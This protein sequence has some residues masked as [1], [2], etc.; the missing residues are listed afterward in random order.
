MRLIFRLRR[1]KKLS[2]Q[3]IELTYTVLQRA[4]LTTKPNCMLKY[5]YKLVSME[6]MIKNKCMLLKHLYVP[7]GIRLASV[8]TSGDT[9]V[10]MGP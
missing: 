9:R 6:G 4:S 5:R 7:A 8:P 3:G 1:K 2:L 10:S